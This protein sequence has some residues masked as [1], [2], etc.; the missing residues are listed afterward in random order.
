MARK[1]IIIWIVIIIITVSVVYYYIGINNP[2]RVA[3][4]TSRPS[5]VW[6]ISAYPMVLL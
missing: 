2:H 5:L 1:S 4:K 3:V 6:S